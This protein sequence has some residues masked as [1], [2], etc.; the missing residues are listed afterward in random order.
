M[1]ILPAA[2]KNARKQRRALRPT[3]ADRG[4]RNAYYQ[5]L[6]GQVRYLKWQTAHLSSLITVGTDRL[7]VART[8]TALSDEARARAAQYA[9]AI[10]SEFVTKV[11][12]AQKQ[13]LE[14]SIA[15]AFGVDF[16]RI[17]DEPQTAADVEMATT[18]NV[19][20]ITSI[21]D[22]HFATIGQALLDNYRGVPLPGGVSLQQRLQDI[23]G[24]T[25][26]RAYLIARDQTAK[27]TS[28]LNSSRQQSNGIEEYRWR[29]TRDSREV[30]NPGGLYPKGTALHGNH[31]ER[32]G[33]TYRW[34]DPPEDGNPGEPIQCRCFAEPVL[35][36]AKLK[37]MYV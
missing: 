4:A 26:S 34:D 37:A 36:L 35:D 23:G 16:A 6:Q 3:K 20:L 7:T 15:S 5:A 17:M 13:A 19:G 9:P 28:A 2:A 29:G 21:S 25:D 32:E 11:D 22:D 33:K 10:A 24:V 8:L 18:R 1:I 31:W 30:G 12:Q 14:C 27:L